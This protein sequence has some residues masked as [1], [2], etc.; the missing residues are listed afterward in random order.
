[1]ALK[2]YRAEADKARVLADTAKALDRLDP[3]LAADF[4]RVNGM[5]DGKS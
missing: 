5:T 2:H 1:M 4:R 3:K